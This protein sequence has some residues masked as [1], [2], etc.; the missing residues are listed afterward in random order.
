MALL[1]GDWQYTHLGPWMTRCKEFGQSSPEDDD[2]F[3][4]VMLILCK[5]EG[6]F[7]TGMLCEVKGGD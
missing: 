5:L 3:T 6:F 7:Y 4:R 1:P 2:T